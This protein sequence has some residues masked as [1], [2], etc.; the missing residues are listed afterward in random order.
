[1][2][3][4][5]VRGCTPRC[6]NACLWVHHFRLPWP[7][8]WAWTSSST[9][10]SSV[11]FI[12]ATASKTV[13]SLSPGMVVPRADEPTRHVDCEETGHHVERALQVHEAPRPA[14]L[15]GD[16]CGY[17]PDFAPWGLPASGSLVFIG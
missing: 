10:D 17:R 14:P 6:W 1:M 8:R 15:A 9:V 4:L 13:S 7:V 12:S 3:L 5:I 16:I 2:A 11:G